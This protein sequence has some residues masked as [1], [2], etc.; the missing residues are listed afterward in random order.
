MSHLERRAGSLTND[1]RRRSARSCPARRSPQDTLGG[2]GEIGYEVLQWI[3]PESASWTARAVRA[4]RVPSTRS[5]TCRAASRPTRRE[6]LRVYTVG[7]LRS[8]PIPNVVLK[9]DYRNR[10]AAARRAGRRDQSGDRSCLLAVDSGRIGLIF[11]ALCLASG[12]AHA[13]V[14]HS[15]TRR[16][17][18]RFPMPIAIDDESIRARRRAGARRSSELAQ[19]Q[20]ESRLVRIY[21]RLPR[22][23]SCSAT[24]S[25]TSTPC[26]RCPRRSWSC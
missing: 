24:R 14:F 17:R 3:A 11:A 6:Q 4:R 22:R 1:L 5:T 26:A 12:A 16:S 15:R 21:T 23:P 9:F 10:V 25:S 2:Y 20:L 19:S 8:K 13:K 7:R 18:S